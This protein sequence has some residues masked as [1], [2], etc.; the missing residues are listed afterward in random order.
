[1]ARWTCKC[2]MMGI[3]ESLKTALHRLHETPV[4]IEAAQKRDRDAMITDLE[5]RGYEVRGKSDEQ[6]EQ[7]ISRSPPS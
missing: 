5:L 2:K 6:I 3:S 1:M 4:E 7:I